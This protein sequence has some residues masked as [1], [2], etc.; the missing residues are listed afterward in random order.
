MARRRLKLYGKKATPEDILEEIHRLL[1]AKGNRPYPLRPPEIAKAIG[2]SRDTVYNYIK[3]LSKRGDVV[4]LPSGHFFFPKTDEFRQFNK[5][6]EIT[7][8]P[9]ISE[10]MDDLLTRKQGLPVKTWR[11]RL[12]SVEIVCNTCKVSPYDLTIS[13]RKTEKILRTFAK[14]FQKG[15][16]VC[17]NRGRKSLG[18]NTT[19]YNKVQAVRDFCS[20]Y[21][22]TWRKGVS[23]IMSQK[24]PNHGKY[25]DI[26]FT[27]EE[28]DGADKF[29]KERW[30][31]DSDVYRWFWVGIESCARLNA[32]YHMK[33][34]WSKIET[35]S[36]KIVFLMSAIE[37]KTD[38]IRGGKWT[39]FITRKD[40][41]ISLELLRKR[42]CA[43]IYES[44]LPEY[45]F[46]QKINQHLVEIYRHLGK[47]EFYFQQHPCH[48]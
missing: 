7:S 5:H 36:G 25:A 45:S 8:D 16:V 44:K 47:K 18:M 28:F 43:R 13:T 24:V 23:G 3:K 37:S 9:M 10:W 27:T 21:D 11:N 33:N 42:H 4:R 26:R 46:K 32:L 12:R 14:H 39:K 35:K 19:V 30:G 34:D 20:F 6:H 29:I 41:Q 40:T 22:I 48:A 15:D 17:S 2:I 31:I 38:N 1:F